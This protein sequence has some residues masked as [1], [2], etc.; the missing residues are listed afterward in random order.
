[1]RLLQLHKNVELRL[2]EYTEGDVP[3]YAILSHRWGRDQDEVTFK[4]VMENTGKDKIGYQKII[5]CGR[6]AA[7]DGYAFLWADTCCIDKNSSSE[8]SEAINSMWNY[9]SDCQVCYAY[10]NDVAGGL[11]TAERDEAFAASK[12]FTRGWT[13][14]ELLAPTILVLFD[15]TWNIIGTKDE[16]AKRISDITN[17]DLRHLSGDPLFRLKASIAERMSWASNRSTK[18]SEDI[19]YCLLGIFDINMPLLYGEGTNAFRRLQ[20]EIMKQSTDLS[21]LAWEATIRSPWMPV[22]DQEIKHSRINARTFV[23][24]ALLAPSPLMFRN[25][26]DIVESHDVSP[27][28][29]HTITNRGFQIELPVVKQADGVL[30]LLNCRRASDYLS[31]LALHLHHSPPGND[32]YRRASGKLRTIPTAHRSRAKLQSMYITSGHV[33]PERQAARWQDLIDETNSNLVDEAHNEKTRRP[34]EDSEPPYST[35]TV[36]LPRDDCCI[37]RG[38]PHDYV[39]SQ[40]YPPRSYSPLTRCIAVESQSSDEAW[41]RPRLLIISSDTLSSIALMVFRRTVLSREF[42]DVRFVPVS[43]RKANMERLYRQWASAD[44]TRLPWCQDFSSQSVVLR[45]T[46]ML[47]RGT[48]LSTI[49]VVTCPNQPTRLFS[50]LERIKHYCRLVTYL[51]FLA[52]NF[53]RE[54]RKEVAYPALYLVVFFSHQWLRRRLKPSNLECSQ[55]SF[56]AISFPLEAGAVLHLIM[57]SGFMYSSIWARERIT[58]DVD[59]EKWKYGTHLLGHGYGPT[60]LQTLWLSFVWGY[61]TNDPCVWYESLLATFFFLGILG[62]AYLSR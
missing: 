50:A 21:I 57:H 37:I 40:I 38:L 2:V 52:R 26:T 10:L 44:L 11:S 24:G 9:Y 54:F 41:R 27:I 58:M 48:R 34:S 29:H 20:E 62:V 30:V 13:L 53:S 32:Q 8:L 6:Q 23:S 61:N 43:T 59:P 35:R 36:Q 31:D 15:A 60:L 14:Q 22:K 33:M 56:W 3:P 5:A 18:R 4:D 25:C 45:I 17:I 12:W 19:A 55:A 49:D 7:K 47:V 51:F 16:L 46:P 39:I 42:T 1:M 28:K